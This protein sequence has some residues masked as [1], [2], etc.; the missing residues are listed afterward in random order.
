MLPM[1]DQIS[2]ALAGLR[3]V[4]GDKEREARVQLRCHSALSR[5]VALRQKNTNGWRPRLTYVCAAALLCVYLAT[6][7][8]QALRLAG[9]M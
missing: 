6:I 5:R 4:R 8:A 2:S 7:F 3:P 1:D 9:H